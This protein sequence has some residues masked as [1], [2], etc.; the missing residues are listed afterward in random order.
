MIVKGGFVT[1]AE[2]EVLGERIQNLD[3]V[4]HVALADR[5]VHRDYF[6]FVRFRYLKRFFESVQEIA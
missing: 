6:V 4:A 5:N 3:T 1:F 2:E